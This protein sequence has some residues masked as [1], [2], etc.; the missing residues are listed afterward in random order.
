[1]EKQ[2]HIDLEKYSLNKFKNNL[3][4]RD[5]IPS[6]VILKE[7]LDE[8]FKVLEICGI[9]N[10]KELTDTLK[11]KQK[12]ELFSEETGLSIEYLTILNREAKS[13]LPNPIRLD[14]FA[15]IPV[16]Y[17][18]RLEAQG[19][20]NTR[21]LFFA[22]KGKNERE[23]LA[24]LVEIPIEI[25]NELVCLADL[26]RIYGVGPVFARMIFDVG[27]HSVEEFVKVTAE[28]FIRIY[29]ER[30]Q[31]KADFGINEIQ[32]SLQLAKELDVAIEL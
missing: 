23:Q 20:K 8:R 7:D 16:E 18:N 27:I 2:Y 1:M 28:E 31:K 32:F 19:I 24:Q 4:S 22:A 26:A 9:K 13:Y 6:R 15:G 29:E 17:V 12:I 30:E 25:M 14:K 3:E 5:M 21:Q 10:L 11:T